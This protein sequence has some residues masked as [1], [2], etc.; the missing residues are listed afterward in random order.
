MLNEGPNKVLFRS[1]EFFFQQTKLVT[2]ALTYTGLFV[3]TAVVG[4]RTSRQLRRERRRFLPSD[5]QFLDNYR[6]F[7]RVLAVLSLVLLLDVAE[8]VV[9]VTS[10]WW[11]MPQAAGLLHQLRLFGA[12]FEGWAYGL[13][14]A[15][16]RAAYRATL[17]CCPSRQVTQHVPSPDASVHRREAWTISAPAP[18]EQPQEGLTEPCAN[19]VSGIN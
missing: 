7:R 3:Y 13:L 4:H 2:L 11:P 10:R 18:P 9:R 8:P 16:L 5:Q 17:C 6:A 19:P 12:I 15:K 14:N 1:Q